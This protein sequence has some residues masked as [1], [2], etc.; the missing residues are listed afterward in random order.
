RSLSRTRSS[1]GYLPG[2]PLGVLRV[3]KLSAAPQHYSAPRR[4]HPVPPM[5]TARRRPAVAPLCW[6]GALAAG[7]A[8]PIAAQPAEAPD[9]QRVV[10]TATRAPLAGS[11]GQPASVSVVEEDELALRPIARFGDALA[12]VPGVYVRGS[13]LG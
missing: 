4:S 12:D 7:T 13:A 3:I 1:K 11:L 8:G 5:P 9:L 10:V 2:T 6:L